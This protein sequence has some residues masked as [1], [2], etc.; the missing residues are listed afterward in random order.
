METTTNRDNI[1]DGTDTSWKTGIECKEDL[2]D[3]HEHSDQETE[4][5]D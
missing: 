2:W 5:T 3:R 1:E 4:E